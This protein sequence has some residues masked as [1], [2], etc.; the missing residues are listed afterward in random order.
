MYLSIQ[1]IIYIRS[2]MT[3]MQGEFKQNGSSSSIN[4]ETKLIIAFIITGIFLIIELIGGL[5]SNSLAVLADVGHMLQDV[6][7]LLLSIVAL[8]LYDKGR[9]SKHSFGYKRAEV[10]AAFINGLFLIVISIYLLFEAFQRYGKPEVIDTSIMFTVSFIGIVA[11]VS[12][13]LILYKSSHDDL[14]IKGALLH[15]AG[16]TLGSIGAVIASLLIILT[17]NVIFDILMTLV[18]TILIIFSAISLLK[19][20]IHILMEG[21]PENLDLNVIHKDLSRLKGIKNIHDMHIWSSSSNE[22]LFSGHFVINKD[23]EQCNAI[24]MINNCL[25][26]NYNISHATIQIEHESYFKNCSSCD[27]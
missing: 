26:T 24:S 21:T 4:N 12:I 1:T 16:D 2:K 3:S 5:L 9:D 18:I 6:L 19:E 7:A 15:V 25:S 22:R 10:L 14:N 11:N 27:N 17:G 13:F 20:S 23:L 8:K